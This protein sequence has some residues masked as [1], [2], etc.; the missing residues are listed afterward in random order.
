MRYQASRESV[1]NPEQQML[2]K[3]ADSEPKAYQNAA[4]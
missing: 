1:H 4:A 2:S 3:A